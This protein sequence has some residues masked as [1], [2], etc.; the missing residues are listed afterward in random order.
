MDLRKWSRSLPKDLE[1][2]NVV[3]QCSGTFPVS[4][5]FFAIIIAT[6]SGKK[7]DVF[8]VD[9][10]YWDMQV[11][12]IAEFMHQKDYS[13]CQPSLVWRY[14]RSHVQRMKKKS[15]TQCFKSNQKLRHQDMTKKSSMIFSSHIIFR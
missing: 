11:V 4:E 9:A 6:L 2:M 3:F 10:L 14:Q 1:T 5:V 13:S 12:S 8:L 15:F 7:L